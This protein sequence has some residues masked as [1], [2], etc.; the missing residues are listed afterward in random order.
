[1]AQRKTIHISSTSLSYVEKNE[2]GAQTLFFIHGNSGSAHAWQ[3]QL[4]SPAL[5]AYRLIAFDLP[6]HGESGPIPAD[7]NVLLEMAAILAGAVQQLSEGK[8]FVLVGLSLGTNLAAEMLAQGVRPSGMAL[9]A[10]CIFG[11]GYTLLTI[12]LEG[13]DMSPLFS[14][15]ASPEAVQTC[16]QAA[17]L[18]QDAATHQQLLHDYRSTFPPMRPAFLQAGLQERYSDEVA[19]LKS[20]AFPLLVVFGADERV[21]NPAYLDNAGLPLWQD[22]IFKL[23]G[24]SHFIQLDQSETVNALLQTYAEQVFTGSHAARHRSAVR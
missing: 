3:R 23:P 17:C 24:G 1:M 4:E 20:A 11:R 6:G 8:P 14:E 22:K 10:P 16:I 21:I 19:V 2:A 9:L 7:E 13:V 15:E 18:S 12:G 5:S